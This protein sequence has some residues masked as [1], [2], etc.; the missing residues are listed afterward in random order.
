MKMVWSQNSMSQKLWISIGVG[1][2]IVIIGFVVYIQPF[3]P[4]VQPLRISTEPWPPSNLLLVAE[5]KGF[6]EKNDVQVEIILT[7]FEI[8]DLADYGTGNDDGT[9][10]VL[11]DVFLLNSLFDPSSIVYAFDFSNEGD[12]II[13]KFDTVEELKGKRIGIMEMYSFSYF[14]V[15][16]VLEEHGIDEKDVEFVVVDIYKML[17]AIKNGDI[18]AGHSW[19][20]S[21]RNDLEVKVIADASDVSGI[22]TDVLIIKTKTIKENPLAVEALVR[23]VAEATDYCE[24]NLIECAQII[25]EKIGWTEEEVLLNF[26]SV[27]ILTL[28]DNFEVMQNRESPE[29]LYQSGKF[30]AEKLVEFKQINEMPDFDKTIDPRFVIKIMDERR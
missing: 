29:S 8:G 13:S 10:T 23:S 19:I 16:K 15:L 4:E 17:D 1:L 5:E 22:I 14:F 2:S 11:T 27:Q 20:S 18:D 3:E 9:T 7:D 26:N 6:F 30:I 24:I 12:F 21:D 28:E 25:S